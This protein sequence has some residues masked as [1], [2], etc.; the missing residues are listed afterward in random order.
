[1]MT[2]FWYLI[3]STQRELLFFSAI[4]FLIG[5]V[6]ELL[7]DIFWVTH[8]FRRWHRRYRMIAP[9]KANE[10]AAPAKPGLIVLFIPAWREAQVVEQ[11]LRRCIAAW[12]GGHTRYRIYIGCYPNDSASIEAAR[13]GISGNAHCRIVL[14][15]EEGPTTKADCLNRLWR[16]LITDELA[17]GFKAKAVV[18]HDAEDYVH[19][20][21]LRIFDLLIEKASAVQ[22]PVIPMEVEG[23]AWISGHYCDEFAE[24]HGK[25]LVVREAAGAALPL[26]GVGCAIERNHLG[27]IA[28]IKGGVPFDRNSL[29]ED[30]E[31]G[32][33]I[34]NR[35][36][37]TVFAR[38]NDAS[39]VLVGTRAC[40]PDT[41]STAVRQKTRWMIGIAL[42]GWD[43]LGW[44][45]GVA[46][47]W[48][49]MRDRKA[50]FSA[51]VL[52][53]AYLCIV[54][55]ALLLL[56]DSAGLYEPKPPD[57]LVLHL[58]FANAIILV[59]RIMV[60]AYFVARVQGRRAALLSIPRTLIANIISI[61]AARRAVIGYTRHLFGQKLLWDK[62][63]HTHFPTLGL[64]KN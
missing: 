52:A 32:L 34:M 50:I 10:L 19:T 14:C 16:A 25:T 1:M 36:E 60:R 46:E 38:I 57:L 59:W 43:R 26:A 58:L 55:T 17:G 61:L 18:L 56:G 44:Q 5:A 54:I 3:Q 64:K 28:L 42:A 8:R 9:L 41:L 33:G 49:R 35:G 51:I 62:T 63:T 37:R 22:L 6:D 40:F 53:A 24:A 15:R 7:V 11:M 29:T 4:W 45:G 27:R 23:S 13:R 47:F 20:D 39:G 30:Y 21:E 12:T 31:L 2:E 48:M